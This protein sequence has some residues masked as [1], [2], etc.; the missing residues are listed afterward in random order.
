MPYMLLDQRRYLND[1]YMPGNAEYT[2]FLE[3]LDLETDNLLVF[4]EGDIANKNHPIL[5]RMAGTAEDE[6][7]AALER[8]KR[9]QVRLFRARLRLEYEQDRS[10]RR[11]RKLRKEECQRIQAQDQLAAAQ[12]ELRQVKDELVATQAT[13]H[14]AKDELTNERSLTARTEG[15]FLVPSLLFR[16]LGQSL[17]LFCK[18]SVTM[19]LPIAIYSAVVVAGL[20]SWLAGMEFRD[21]IAFVGCTLAV[22]KI[23]L[24][25]VKEY[26]EKR[27]KEEEKQERVETSLAFVETDHNSL[28]LLRMKVTLFNPSHK[29][30]LRIKTVSLQYTEGSKTRLLHLYTN[31][32]ASESSGRFQGYTGD[33][34]VD[35]EPRKSATFCALHGQLSQAVCDGVSSSTA[36][37]LEIVVSSHVGPIGRIDGKSVWEQLKEA[38]RRGA[39]INGPEYDTVCPKC[40]KQTVLVGNERRCN[41]HKCPQAHRHSHAKCPECGEHATTVTG[42]TMRDADYLCPNGH[43]F[44]KPSQDNR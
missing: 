37:D 6:I 4:L 36:D 25:L 7:M 39:V 12:A 41:D 23:G 40:G 44:S 15:Y 2:F 8:W 27:A 42:T 11:L 1:P 34:S 16:P 22:C 32:R 28:V 30:P 18:R 38:E 29:V 13:L 26:Q 19:Y 21:T 43:A 35:I 33:A 24:D 14:R 9:R 31:V 5:L 17:T 20:V 10:E 3:Y